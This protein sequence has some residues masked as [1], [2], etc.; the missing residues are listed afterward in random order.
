MAVPQWCRPSSR[1]IVVWKCLGSSP[2]ADRLGIHFGTQIGDELRDGARAEVTFGTVTDG[3]GA[4]FSFLAADDEHVGY[5]LQLRVADL[6]LE[7]F[8]AVVEMDAETRVFELQRDILR[9]QD[10]FFAQRQHARL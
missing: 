10:S 1:E 3:N 5:F 2:L 9:V 4:C 6:R 8:V 7:F